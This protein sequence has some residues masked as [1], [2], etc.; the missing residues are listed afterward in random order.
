MYVYHHNAGSLRE[1]TV[2]TCRSVLTYQSEAEFREDSSLFI[3]PARVRARDDL[4]APHL[5]FATAAEVHATLLSCGIYVTRQD[6]DF[7]HFLL[8]KAPDDFNPHQFLCGLRPEAQVEVIEPSVAY[9]AEVDVLRE[10][11]GD[12][13]ALPLSRAEKKRIA[14]GLFNTHFAFIRGG[15]HARDSVIELCLFVLYAL[16]H[17]EVTISD[18][19]TRSGQYFDVF[20]AALAGAQRSER[21]RLLS[22]AGDDNQLTEYLVGANIRV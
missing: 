3:R 9:A 19:G 4:A 8:G 7:Q 22:G 20:R 13:L 5:K 14:I 2:E 18:L 6:R 12:L 11:V 17:H 1:F 15:V 10:I 21:L 16:L